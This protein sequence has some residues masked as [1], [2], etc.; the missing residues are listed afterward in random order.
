ML[1]ICRSLLGNPLVLLVDEPSEGLAP[2]IVEVVMEVLLDIQ[3]KGVTV[4]LVEQKLTIA[5][6]TSTMLFVMGHGQIV[7]TGT[8]EELRARSDIRR[9]WLEAA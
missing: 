5:L 8:A 9:D 4:V 2:K 1:T 6:K 3:K 7:F